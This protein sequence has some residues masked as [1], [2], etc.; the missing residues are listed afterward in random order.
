V[1]DDGRELRA[2]NAVANVLLVMATVTLLEV[3][4]AQLARGARQIAADLRDSV[5]SPFLA[6][7]FI[8]PIVIGTMK[9]RAGS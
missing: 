9:V 1:A 6:L 4:L 7:T 2:P 3:V 8:V 5:L